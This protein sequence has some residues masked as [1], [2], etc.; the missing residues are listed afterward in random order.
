MGLLARFLGRSEVRERSK[1]IVASGA[2]YRGVQI[3]VGADGCCRQ[4]EAAARDRF[5][6]H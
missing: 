6:A 2:R 1:D 4:A 3:I 5:L